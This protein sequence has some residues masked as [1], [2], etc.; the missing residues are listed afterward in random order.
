MATR[1]FHV[2]FYEKNIFFFQN[3]AFFQKSI[4]LKRLRISLDIFI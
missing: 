2:F 1:I 4:F 3:A